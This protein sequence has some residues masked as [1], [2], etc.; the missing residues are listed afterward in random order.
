VLRGFAPFLKGYTRFVSGHGGCEARRL[1][2]L[3]ERPRLAA[4]VAAAEADPSCACQSLASLLVMPVQR[5]PR[6]VLLL[7]ELAKHTPVGHA[8][9]R[10]TGRALELVTAVAATLNDAIARAEASLGVLALQA[11]LTPH[12]QPSL[13]A[14]HRLLV[15]CG[16]LSK[17][18]RPL[19]RLQRYAVFLLSGALCEC[20]WCVHARCRQ[21]AR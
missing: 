17:L 13:V 3:R 12:P 8:D 21:I 14:P 2:L 7:R 4:F 6:Y 19:P 16:W 5:V 10:E 20:A 1:R 9:A 11:A 18:C 15:R